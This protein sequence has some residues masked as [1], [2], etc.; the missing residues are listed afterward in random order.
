MDRLKQKAT[1]VLTVVHV[2]VHKKRFRRGLMI[3]IVITAAAHYVFPEYEAMLAFVLNMAFY[4][5]P[6]VHDLDNGAK[7]IKKDIKEAA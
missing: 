5:D 3:T 1:H 2:H 7:D 4:Y 6:I